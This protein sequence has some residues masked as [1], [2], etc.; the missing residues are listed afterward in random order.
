MVDEF[1]SFAKMPSTIIEKNDICDVIKQNII[2]YKVS[3]QNI[4]FI[5]NLPEHKHFLTL[6]VV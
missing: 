5:S 3:N 1:A 2:M 4:E 6:I